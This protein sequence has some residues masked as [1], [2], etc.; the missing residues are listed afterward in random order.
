MPR[1]VTA[2]QSYC[3]AHPAIPKPGSNRNAPFS[4]S[5]NASRTAGAFGRRTATTR[6]RKSRPGRAKLL[7]RADAGYC[8]G[9]MGV[10]HHSRSLFWHQDVR[11]LPLGSRNSARHAD[12]SLEEA[13]AAR[14]FPAGRDACRTTQGISAH[15]NGLRSLSELHRS[16]AIWRPMA[17]GQQTSAA[18]ARPCALRL[19]EP[20][21][22]RLLRMFKRNRS[23]SGSI[24]GR[25][26]R[27]PQTFEAGAEYQTGI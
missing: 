9:C 6:E 11:S 23:Q 25:T 7:C 21:D 1:R 8:F 20:P 22:C 27:R 19:R 16:D 12:G 10:S 17:L 3:T 2:S 13:D 4:D 14:D 15:Q 26:W 5:Q 24:S 18:R